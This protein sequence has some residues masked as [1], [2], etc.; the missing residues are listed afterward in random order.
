MTHRFARLGLACALMMMASTVAYAQGGSTTAPLSGTVVDAS[1]AAIPGASVTVRNNATGASYQ[2]VSS[3]KGT[4]TVPAL[5]AGT[6][7]VT[8]SLSGFK[9]AVIQDIKLLA[10]TPG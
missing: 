8:V 10:A 7:T 6:Y 2:A 1:G 9:Q 4:F 5:Q 3:D